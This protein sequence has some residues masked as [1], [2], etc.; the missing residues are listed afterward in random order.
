[1]TEWWIPTPGSTITGFYTEKKIYRDYEGEY[2]DSYV[3]YLDHV[4][5]NRI[6]FGSFLLNQ[7][8][9][10]CEYGDFVWI[11]YLGLVE[12]ENGNEMKK[13]ICKKI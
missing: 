6:F 5:G 9:N 1:M 3:Y 4:D 8:F 10:K 2:P 11:K 7:F 13:Y 12:L